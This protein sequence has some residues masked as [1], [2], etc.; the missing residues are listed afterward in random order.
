MF[1]DFNPEKYLHEM[2]FTHVDTF[3]KIDPN[4]TFLI[5]LHSFMKVFFKFNSA[6]SVAKQDHN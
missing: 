3:A 1:Y 5:L 2:A 4:S 6:L